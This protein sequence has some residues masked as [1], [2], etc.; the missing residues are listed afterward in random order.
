MTKTINTASAQS[1]EQ[2]SAVEPR[3][4][5]YPLKTGGS[6]TATCPAWC[7]ADHSDDVARGIDP[8]GLFHRRQ[9]R[10]GVQRG[11]PRHEHPRGADRAIRSP[12]EPAD[13]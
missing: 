11:W 3:T 1:S 10:A 4:I 2:A 7:T 8:A 9:G 12:A 13:G 5:T 6:I